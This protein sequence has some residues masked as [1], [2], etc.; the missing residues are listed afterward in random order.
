MLGVTCHLHFWQNDRGHLR[1][2]AVTRGWGGTD[3]RIRMRV[4]TKSYLWREKKKF[5]RRSSRDS[6]SQPFDHESG[7]LTN[8]LSR[9]SLLQT[10]PAKRQ[11]TNPEWPT[12]RLEEKSDMDTVTTSSRYP[13]WAVKREEEVRVRG[14]SVD[15]MTCDELG[16]C[17]P[18]LLSWTSPS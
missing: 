9:F 18:T 8:K 17:D 5:S 14:R 15:A 12:Q 16:D 10:E 6:N 2:T 11:S 3:L 13:R 4:S 1:A 7:A